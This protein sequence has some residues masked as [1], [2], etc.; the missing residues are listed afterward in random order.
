MNTETGRILAKRKH[1][2]LKEFLSEFHK[3]W[4]CEI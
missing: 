3:E 4:N 2:F 1:H